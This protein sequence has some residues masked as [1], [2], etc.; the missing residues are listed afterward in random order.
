MPE[1]WP[2]RRFTRYPIVLP[3]LHGGKGPALASTGVGWTCDLSGGGARVRLAERFGPQDSLH[4]RFQTDVGAIE[5]DAQVVWTGAPDPA[6]G[7]IQHGVAFTNLSPDQLIPLRGVLT[8]QKPWWQPRNRLPVDVPVTCQLQR[9]P[10]PAL[11]GRTVNMSRGGLM[12]L[13]PQVL[14]QGTVL[15]VTLQT[16]PGL[17]TAAGTIVWADLRG[18]QALEKLIRHGLSFTA[19][20]WST[21]LALARF[22]A[23]RR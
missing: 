8:S 3:L 1:Y 9:R 12:L 13:L 7:G 15:E 6:G 21:S 19:V 16:S 11:Q 22:L 4:L 10:G 5:G 14:S 17:L 2:K 23:E 20:N 18:R